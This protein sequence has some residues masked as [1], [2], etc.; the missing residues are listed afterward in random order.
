MSSSSGEIT[1]PIFDPSLIFDGKERPGVVVGAAGYVIV[2]PPLP[3]FPLFGGQGFDPYLG[4]GSVGTGGFGDSL[5]VLDDFGFTPVGGGGGE[6]ARH[7][8]GEV[9]KS[10]RE[11][12]WAGEVGGR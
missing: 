4:D 10:V 2:S 9:P 3:I 11:K 5:V 7:V 8:H 12:Q 1:L 6:V